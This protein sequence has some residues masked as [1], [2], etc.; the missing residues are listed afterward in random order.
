MK[1]N[2]GHRSA[3]A[4]Q[5]AN[6]L[7]VIPPAFEVRGSNNDPPRSWVGRGLINLSEPIARPLAEIERPIGQVEDSLAVTAILGQP[8]SRVAIGVERAGDG[9]AR[10]SNV[11]NNDD[12]HQKQRP[13]RRGRGSSAPG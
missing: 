1:G 3:T 13:R 6:D 8:V 10:I 2:Q 9:Q 12:H 7:G 4:Y 5:V 11:R